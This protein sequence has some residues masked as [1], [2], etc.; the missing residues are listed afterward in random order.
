MNVIETIMLGML[1]LIIFRKW[2]NRI[3]GRTLRS[4]RNLLSD[5]TEEAL[6]VLGRPRCSINTQ[7]TK[8]TIILSLLVTI[9]TLNLIGLRMQNHHNI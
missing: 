3:I 8:I 5:L 9:I 6:I 4:D 7:R 1:D 2:I